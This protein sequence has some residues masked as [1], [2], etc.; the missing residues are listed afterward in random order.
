MKILQE[1]SSSNRTGNDILEHVGVTAK[2]LWFVESHLGGELSLDS[3]SAAIGVSRFH[4]SRAFPQS[5]GMP[6]S[7]YIRARRLG[8]A[9]KRVA[10]GAPDILD[11]ALDAGY[12]SHEAF[13]RSFRQLFGLTPEQ[14][15]QQGSTD[16]LKIQE[17]ARIEQGTTVKLA[18]P[19]IVQG[20]A[21]LIFGLGQRYQCESNAGIPAQWDKFL[22]HFCAI[23]RQKGRVAYGVICNPDERGSYE[24]ICG[25]EVDGFPPEPSHF[26]RLEIAGG[27]YAVFHHPGHISTIHATW[28][29][30]WNH[31]LTEA[32]FQAIQQPAFERYGENFDGRSGLGGVEIWI[33]I[34]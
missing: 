14:V 5:M 1:R 24:Y 25:V 19:R 23:P 32:G 16:G 34:A 27:K 18:P 22:P 17:P 15:R 31:G 2:A 33:A 9:A 20:S 8:E 3:V 11:V 29:A 7:G 13:T 28:S 6:V 30:V 26:S 12:G 10:A 21:R 4:L